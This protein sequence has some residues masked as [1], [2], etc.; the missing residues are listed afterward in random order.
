[1]GC[2]FTI[3][4]VCILWVPILCVQHNE[5]VG[6]RG[7]EDS[8]KRVARDRRQEREKE[9]DH[10]NEK[11]EREENTSTSAETLGHTFL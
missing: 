9:M 11:S 1:M 5:R 6:K 8:C 4:I 3:A 2:I 7:V 10:S